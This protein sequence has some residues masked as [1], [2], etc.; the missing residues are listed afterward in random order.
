VKAAKLVQLEQ[1]QKGSLV[2][3]PIAV[4]YADKEWKCLVKVKR[5]STKSKLHML[6]S[7]GAASQVCAQKITKEKH[8]GDVHATV[9]CR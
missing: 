2:E 7:V 6:L 8:V 9:T 5:H 3:S 4:R 1:L